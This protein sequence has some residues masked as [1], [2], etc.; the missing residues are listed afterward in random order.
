MK[1]ASGESCDVLLLLLR[2]CELAAVDSGISSREDDPSSGLWRGKI[3][4]CSLLAV[5]SH[6]SARASLAAK[7]SA[8]WKRDRFKTA[9]SCSRVA[10]CAQQSTSL[11][12][13][14]STGPSS[15]LVPTGSGVAKTGDT[16]PPPSRAASRSTAEDLT[17]NAGNKSVCAFSGARIRFQTPLRRCIS[18]LV[19][20]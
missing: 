14:S 2:G 19:K 9:M 18:I 17:G 11:N 10:V 16:S 4:S 15:A 13:A 8:H 3:S 7:E 5:R 1:P 6:S 20:G 12:S